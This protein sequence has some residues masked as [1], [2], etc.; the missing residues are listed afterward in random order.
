M[1]EPFLGGFGYVSADNGA[2]AVTKDTAFM[3]A[4]VSK[5]FAGVSVMKLIEDGFISSEQ[6]DICE[7]LPDNYDAS[8]CRNPNFESVPVTWAHIMTHTASM[9]NGVPDGKRT[10]FMQ[11]YVLVV[12]A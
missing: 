12:F 7:V 11:M 1:S 10:T 8:A 5:V 2:Q 3:I 9:L 6:E 4:S